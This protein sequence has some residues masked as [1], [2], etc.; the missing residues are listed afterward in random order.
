[1]RDLTTKALVECAINAAHAAEELGGVVYSAGIS[2]G[3]GM[4]ILGALYSE[5]VER[6]VAIA[7]SFGI[8]GLLDQLRPLAG[9][10]Y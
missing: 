1:M 2:V 6:V 10:L 9:R 8:K 7:P 4:S 3:A 5:K